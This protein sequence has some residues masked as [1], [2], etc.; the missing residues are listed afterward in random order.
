RMPLIDA[1][2]GLACIAIVWHHLAFYGPMSDIARPLMPGLIDL[3]Y[4]DGRMA[5]Q[6]F[7]V[8]AGYLC[9]ARLAPLGVRGFD[10]AGVQI[11]RR[12]C[13][14]ATPYA[15]ALALAILA[16]MLVRPWLSDDSVPD[17]PTA[18]Q[19]LAHAFL[20]QDLTG[21]EALSAGVWYV[22]ID[23]QLFVLAVGLFCLGGWLQRHA[24]VRGMAWCVALVVALAAVSL[25]WFNRQARLD[26]TAFYF[27]GAYGLGM[28]AYW[29]TRARY[30]QAWWCALACLGG[31]AL[32]LEFRG[33]IA[34]AL[35]TALLLAWA[36]RQ[37]WA[38]R[39]WAHGGALLHVGRVSYS[40]FLVHFSVCL[41]VNA[42][43][44]DLWPRQ[45]WVNALGMLL[46][47]VL[48][49]AAGQ[50]LYTLVES[51]LAPWA[52]SLR[53]YLGVCCAGVFLALAVG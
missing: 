1:L 23:F 38:R 31:A 46:A 21:Q 18:P 6:V 37:P 43:V 45:P 27:F 52:A 51:R 7:L 17:A 47:F 50:G 40:I 2:K 49:L 29:A 13:R 53:L 34:V 42:V 8:V 36:G 39:P 15:A 28:L 41:L 3:L 4:A 30:P 16:A 11:I 10:R 20:L 5:V 9:V 33:R 32:A 12:F 24:H 14:L 35:A 22:A 26:V 25:G 19:L 48:S 44:G